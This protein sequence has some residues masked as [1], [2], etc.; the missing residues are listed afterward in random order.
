MSTNKHRKRWSLSEKKKILSY[1]EVHGLAR[2]MREYNVSHSSIYNWK[3]SIVSGEKKRSSAKKKKESATLL[4]L[5][6]LRRENAQLK[7]IVA[8]KELS[9][10]IQA[11]LLKKSH[12]VKT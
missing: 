11:E 2:T 12:F 3:E 1:F 10:R 5:K 4:E 8:E 6:S 9:I 7:A